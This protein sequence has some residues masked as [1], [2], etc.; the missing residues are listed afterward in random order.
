MMLKFNISHALGHF[1]LAEVRDKPR[2]SGWGRI[3]RTAKPSSGK[4]QLPEGLRRVV[5]H[6]FQ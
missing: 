2:P 6:A 1:G 5:R 4:I 3:A